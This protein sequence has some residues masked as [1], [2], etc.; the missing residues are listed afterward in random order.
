[1]CLGTQEDVI[2]LVLHRAKEIS[3]HRPPEVIGLVRVLAT[4][5][6]NSDLV[7]IIRAQRDHYRPG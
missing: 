4:R 2:V 1:M 5:S 7:A 6:G 3:I